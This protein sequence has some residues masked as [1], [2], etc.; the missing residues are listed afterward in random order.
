MGFRGEAN[1]ARVGEAIMTDLQA[2][3][4]AF[5]EGFKADW[6]LVV[7]YRSEHGRP[8]KRIYQSHDVLAALA[9]KYEPGKE[10]IDLIYRSDI[11]GS[12]KL[13]NQEEDVGFQP[14]FHD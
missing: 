8:I 14:N 6:Q 9:D 5:H 7:W 1:Q 10:P 12:T 13:P 2:A 11:V 4:M 3:V